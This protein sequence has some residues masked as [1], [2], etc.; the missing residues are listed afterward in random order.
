MAPGVVLE[1]AADPMRFS[2]GGGEGGN[3]QFSM[4]VCGGY[5]P[6]GIE[7]WIFLYYVAEIRF[8]HA[9]FKSGDRKLASLD[10]PATSKNVP[11]FLSSQR[12]HL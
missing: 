9:F 11:V 1:I 2:M 8:Y 7:C 4:F 12:S 6:V 5:L 3:S 10:P